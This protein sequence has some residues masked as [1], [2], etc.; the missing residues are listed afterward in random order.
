MLYATMNEAVCLHTCSI[1]CSSTCNI[2][3]TS[4]ARIRHESDYSTGQYG[5]IYYH[6][7]L[8][9]YDTSRTAIDT[10]PISDI[11]P[12]LHMCTPDP[13]YFTNLPV[14]VVFRLLPTALSITGGSLLRIY[15]TFGP[16]LCT[17]LGTG[18][19]ST[20]T[21]AVASRCRCI[22]YSSSSCTGGGGGGTQPLHIVRGVSLRGH[23]AH[24]R[25]ARHPRAPQRPIHPVLRSRSRMSSSSCRISGSVSEKG[26]GD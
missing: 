16:V 17:P 13:H 12:R 25:S 5:C 3:N 1:V 18:F 7:L 15:L 10:T 14:L 2:N 23:A 6:Q 11:P 22:G 20:T 8:F 9:L 26:C 24:P 21:V 4:T 19:I